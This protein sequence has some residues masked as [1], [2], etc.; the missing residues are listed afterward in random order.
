[1]D[2]YLIS[3]REASKYFGIGINKFY[4][5][6]RSQ[7]DMPVVKIGEHHKINVPLFKKWLDTCAEEGRTL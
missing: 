1:M 2:K 6:L 5:L 3:V 4:E 7:P